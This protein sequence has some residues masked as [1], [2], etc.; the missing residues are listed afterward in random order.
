MATIDAQELRESIGRFRVLIVGRANAGKTTILQKVCNTTD[1]PE[2]YDAKGNKIDAGVV[3]ASIKRGN[4]DI[5]N[6]MVF[7][8]NSGFVFHDS[9][10]FEAGSEEEF[11]SMKRFISE[12]VH[13][14]KLEERIHA[15]WYCIPMD[16]CC[17]TFQRSEEKFFLECD[18]G[19]VPVITVFTKFEAL[20]PVAYGEIKKEIKGVS[21]EERSE[22]IA[23]RVEELFTKTGVCDRLCDP[24]NRTRPKFHVRLEN[25]N[26]PNTNCNTLLERT[27]FALDND[28][29]RLCLVSTQQSNLELCIKCAVVTL[30]DRA[31]QQSV[32]RQVDYEVNQYAIAKWF[33]HLQVRRGFIQSNNTLVMVLINGSQCL[34]CL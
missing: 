15:I 25:M 13:A 29:L 10:G 12:R 17:R 6:E 9:C 18:T 26:K 27:T 14:T 19:H 8:S 22:R 30:V 31:H 4:H 32:L 23:Q 3:E 21:A 20:R 11:E 34:D 7:K 1:Q 16:E 24:E 28:E 2:V 5:T 33:A